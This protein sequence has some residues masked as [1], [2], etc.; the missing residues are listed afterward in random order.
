MTR[1]L[2]PSKLS[3]TVRLL[4]P[5]HESLRLAAGPPPHGHGPQAWR[6]GLETE[7]RVRRLLRP[8]DPGP[9]RRA[10]VRVLAQLPGPAGPQ[11]RTTLRTRASP[12]A[13]GLP[14]SLRRK[15]GSIRRPSDGPTYVGGGT[16]WHCLAVPGHGCI[17][18]PSSGRGPGTSHAAC[19]CLPRAAF[20]KWRSASPQARRRA[21]VG[22]HWTP[23][24]RVI[25]RRLLFQ[26]G[27]AQAVRSVDKSCV[28]RPAD[29]RTASPRPP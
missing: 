14:G 20:Y 8:V 22:S 7:T 17:P 28:R 18:G 29:R 2:T 19:R 4:D 16:Y 21:C 26:V 10:R 3:V 12:L 13:A 11:S 1:N 24:V 5:S 15:V 6:P 27:Q 25:R 9:V 23:S